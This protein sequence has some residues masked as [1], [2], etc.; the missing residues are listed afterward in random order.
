M[1]FDIDEFGEMSSKLRN[2]VTN[3]GD[4]LIFEKIQ[5]M[6]FWRFRQNFLTPAVQMFGRILFCLKFIA[7]NRSPY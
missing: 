6:E 1:N 7:K 3:F 5:K 4:S 2:D